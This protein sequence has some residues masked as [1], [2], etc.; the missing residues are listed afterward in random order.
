MLIEDGTGSG[1]TAKVDGENQLS[2]RAI[3]QIEAQHVN[4]EEGNAYILFSPLTPDDQ[5]PSAD[6]GSPCIFYIKNTSDNDLIITEVRMWAEAAEYIDI[7]FN[8]SGTPVGGNTATPVNMNLN[9][10]KVADGTFLG[11]DRITGMSGGT[12][13][14]RLRVPA[15]D[16]DHIYTWPAAIIIPKNNILTIYAGNGGIPTEASVFFYYHGEV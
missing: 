7:Y 10:G 14:D 2:T 1:K 3:T 15:D 9:S 16:V 13:F 6:E 11:A 12:L 8:Q 5:N 4:E